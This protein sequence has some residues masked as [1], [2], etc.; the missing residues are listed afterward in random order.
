MQVNTSAQVSNLLRAY[1]VQGTAPPREKP[2]PDAAERQ[3]PAQ[4]L[5]DDPRL[6][7]AR[8]HDSLETSSTGRDLLNE[9]VK[10]ETDPLERAK[11]GD[12]AASRAAQRDED[13]KLGLDKAAQSVLAGKVRTIDLLA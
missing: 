7:I 8:G 5:T 1:S 13:V 6:R 12:D 3:D 4:A 11:Q 10:K 2:G 9:Q